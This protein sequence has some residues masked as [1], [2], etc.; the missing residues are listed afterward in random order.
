MKILRKIALGAG[1]VLALLLAAVG[2]LA[3]KNHFLW[4][5][6]RPLTSRTFA[7][8]PERL[9]RGAY[10]AHSV[11]PCMDCHSPHD[12]TK[13]DAPILP[14]MEGAG[15]DMSMLKG[16][17]GRMVAP[18]LTPDPE[19]GAGNWSDDALA[20]AIREGIGHDGRA[21]FPMMPYQD[22][23]HLSDE[24]LASIVVYLRSLPAVRN[25]LPPTEIIFPVKYL[26]RGVPQPL[27]A[28]VAAPD[29]STGLERGKYLVT[30]AGCADCHTPQRQGQPIA[31]MDYAGGDVLEGPWGRV[32]SANLTP[33]P[34]GIAHYDEAL[35][36]RTIRT[37]YSG[38]RSINQIMPWALYRN[39]SD[40][41]LQAVF[42]YL[43]TLKPVSHRVDNSL[44]ATYC[45]RDGSAHGGGDQNQPVSSAS[46]RP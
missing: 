1:I 41:D 26:I 7:R 15:Q 3:V 6:T 19:T 36:I 38:A 40:A 22:E 27:T 17:P 29:L 28:P 23:A 13:H 34:S 18:N 44:Q 10:L 5:R 16:L 9:A 33:D 39:M 37:G 42:A 46:A 12:W 30:I 24:D 32:A 11:T 20:R 8:T 35:F 25:P 4:P 43:R 45:P 2:V 21:L 31:G 14:G